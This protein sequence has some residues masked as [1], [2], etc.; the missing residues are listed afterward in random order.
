MSEEVTS[1]SMIEEQTQQPDPS[2][3]LPNLLK[4]ISNAP[5]QEQIDN[6]KKEFGEVYVSGF[7]EVELFVWRPVTRPEYIQIQQL[8]Q[9]P[10]QEMT[11]FRLEEFLCDTCVLWKAPEVRSWAQGKAG[12]PQT[13]SEQI[14]SSSNFLSPAAA[15]M[16]VAKL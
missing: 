9:D 8:A 12:T 15:S 3:E 10:K 4:G 5:T 14:M 1:E 7:S 11:Q 16:L 2:T 6:W 13:L